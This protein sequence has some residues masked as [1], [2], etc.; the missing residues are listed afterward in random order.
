MCQ[1][2]NSKIAN[3]NGAC[4]V[5]LAYFATFCPRGNNIHK[6]HRQQTQHP[7]NKLTKL[8]DKKCLK[9]NDFVNCTVLTYNIMYL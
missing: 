6:T 9:K 8:R 5:P 4:I 1:N 2:G 3:C 7:K